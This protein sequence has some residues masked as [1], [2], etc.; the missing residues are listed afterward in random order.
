MPC[1]STVSGFAPDLGLMDTR[2]DI[3]S[4]SSSRLFLNMAAFFMGNVFRPARRTL[5]ILKIYYA[6]DSCM[7]NRDVRNSH[8]LLET[9]L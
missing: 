8:F 6:F 1:F 2:S 4:G 5:R 9:G 3:R 7:C